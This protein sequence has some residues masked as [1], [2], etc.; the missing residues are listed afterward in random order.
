MSS[1]VTNAANF[2]QSR[3]TGTVRPYNDSE[4]KE[5][6][7]EMPRAKY[8]EWIKDESARCRCKYRLRISGPRGRLNNDFVE[9]YGDHDVAD[10]YVATPAVDDAETVGL[11]RGRPL[12]D[13]FKQVDNMNSHCSRR[14]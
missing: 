12:S 14:R 11:K 1:F 5:A 13:N 2:I 9:K 10:D 6:R 4:N 8:L 3:T 7:I